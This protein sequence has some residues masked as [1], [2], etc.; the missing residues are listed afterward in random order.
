MNQSEKKRL[1]E[2][3]GLIDEMEKETFEDFVISNDGED[4]NRN[5]DFKWVAVIF[6]EKFPALANEKDREAL[7]K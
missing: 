6:E 7:I 1:V 2:L 4:Y 5:L 3:W